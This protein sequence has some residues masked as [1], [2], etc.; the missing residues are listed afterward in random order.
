MGLNFHTNSYDEALSLPTETARIA[1]NT[2]LI[3][4]EE[5]DMT[6][7][8]DPFAGSVPW[9]HLLTT[10]ASKQ[11]TY[12]RDHGHGRNDASH[13]IGLPTKE[14]RGLCTVRQARD[15]GIETIVG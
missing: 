7:I 2:Q 8:I 10:Y 12:F 14:N 11:R 6:H 9:N 1:R 5:T 13:R 15:K 4:Q 3:L